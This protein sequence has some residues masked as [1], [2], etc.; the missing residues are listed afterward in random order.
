MTT[1]QSESDAPPLVQIVESYCTKLTTTGESGVEESCGFITPNLATAR[2]Y[3]SLLDVELRT[4]HQRA[5]IYS[6][7]NPRLQYN[8]KGRLSMVGSRSALVM[9]IQL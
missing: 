3:V 2:V 5:R 9:E 1:K 7:V 8:P 6:M 4:R